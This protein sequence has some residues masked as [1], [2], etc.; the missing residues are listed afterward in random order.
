MPVPN[1]N[2]AVLNSVIEDQ[3]PETGSFV[4]EKTYLNHEIEIQVRLEEL[5]TLQE[6]N[7][8][9]SQNNNERKKYAKCIFALTIVWAALIFYHTFYGRK[10]KP[11]YFR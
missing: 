3:S 11:G 4:Q 7:K 2:T 10:K 6:H 1:F 5:K 8:T 9:L